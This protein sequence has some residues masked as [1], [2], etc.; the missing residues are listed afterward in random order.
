MDIFG[1]FKNILKPIKTAFQR[2]HIIMNKWEKISLIIL[3]III[4]GASV[5]KAYQNYNSQTVKVAAYGGKYIEGIVANN[6]ND[7]D[8]V[9]QKLTKIGLTYF[10]NNGALQPALVER[11]EISPDNK[12]YTFY[13]KNNIE[14]FKIAETIKALKNS[15]SEINIETPEKSIIKFT[16][17]EP[18]SPFLNNTAQL[19]FDFG[20]YELKK[21]DKAQLEFFARDNFVFGRSYVKEII[22]KLYPDEENLDRKSVV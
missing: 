11:W 3:F 7:T 13:L 2:F 19:L 17:K 1:Y 16:L 12:T 22:I 20:P 14:S 15:W 10:D 9:I 5:T 8:Q 21:Q 4:A 18:Y 6:K